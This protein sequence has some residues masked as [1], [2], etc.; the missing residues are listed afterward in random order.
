MHKLVRLLR[1]L[2]HQLKILISSNPIQSWKKR[3]V[4]RE[5]DGKVV[6]VAKEFNARKPWVFQ[7]EIDGYPF[8]GKTPST[9]LPAVQ[10]FARAFPDAT[11]IMELGSLEGAETIALSKL[12]STKR[13]LGLEGRDYN[14][15]KAKFIQ[16]LLGIANIEYV[17]ANLEEADLTKYGSFDAVYCRGVLYHLPNPWHLIQ[18]TAQVSP[19]LYLDTHFV[20]DEQADTR[21]DGWNGWYYQEWGYQDP[22]S[23]LSPR[24]FWLSRSSLLRLLNDC[25]YQNVTV[26]KEDMDNPNGPRIT[27][28]ARFE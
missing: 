13:V 4:V 7:F 12:P 18:Q 21:V 27:V 14:V 9:N 6:T 19:R 8:G 22:E 10:G 5:I 26:L 3:S 2:K 11:T 17:V 16:Q 25:G 1:L 23:G 20:T 24:S 15:D 28:V